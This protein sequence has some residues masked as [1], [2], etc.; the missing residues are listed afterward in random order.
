MSAGTRGTQRVVAPTTSAGAT[1]LAMLVRSRTTVRR[2]DGDVAAQLAELRALRDREAIR[3]LALLYTRATDDCD[4]DAVVDMFTDDGVFELRG[5]VAVGTDQLRAAYLVPMK[6][7]RTMRHRVDA[8]VVDLVSDDEA[9]GW[10]TGSAELATT[11][12]VVGTVFR[13]DDRYRRVED[14]WRLAHRSV[15]FMYAVPVAELST[16]LIGPDRIRW[17]GTRPRQA[18]YPESV[19]TWAALKG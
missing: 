11:E 3:D 6:A 10:L 12:S 8:H 7:Y 19:A 15:Q 18:D 1:S 2:D 9:V 13:Y 5:R 4:V 16:A 14:R 17:P